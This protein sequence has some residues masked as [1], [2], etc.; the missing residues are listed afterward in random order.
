MSKNN[1]IPF[2]SMLKDTFVNDSIAPLNWITFGAMAFFA[3]ASFAVFA[4]LPISLFS[5]ARSR[6][7]SNQVLLQ[8]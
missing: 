6:L 2:R 4:L 7:P 5:V 8:V 3:V 1:S